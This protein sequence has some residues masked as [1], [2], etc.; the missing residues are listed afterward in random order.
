MVVLH[1][2][3]GSVNGGIVGEARVHNC[4]GYLQRWLT[5]VDYGVVLWLTWLGCDPRII[6]FL[7]EDPLDKRYSEHRN[8][9]TTINFISSM[10]WLFSVIAFIFPM[11]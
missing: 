1:V 10:M 9:Q 2:I 8:F 11:H 3:L 4:V 6:T 5:R 7:V